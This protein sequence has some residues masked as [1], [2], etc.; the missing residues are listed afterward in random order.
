MRKLLIALLLGTPVFAFAADKSIDFTQPLISVDGKPLHIS[1]EKDSPVATLGD[2]SISALEAISD[3]DRNLPGVEKF[4]R[5]KLA[6]FIYMNK[7]AVLSPEDTALIK[8]RIGKIFGPAVIGAAW[9][10]FGPVS[11]EIK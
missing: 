2:V 11:T 5:D 9:P 6:R 1:G 10:L 7:A 8:E 3:E 4:K